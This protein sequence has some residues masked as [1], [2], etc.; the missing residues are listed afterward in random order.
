[1]PPP[2][3]LSKDALFQRLNANHH[4]SALRQNP[5]RGSNKKTIRMHLPAQDA[6]NPTTLKSY[7]PTSSCSPCEQMDHTPPNNITQP[8][9]HYLL[10]HRDAPFVIKY[11]TKG[12]AERNKKQSKTQTCCCSG[13]I[14]EQNSFFS[15]QESRRDTHRRADISP[16]SI[17]AHFILL[18]CGKKHPIR[19]SKT[20]SA[21]ALFRRWRKRR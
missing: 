9:T 3:S 15:R 19:R 5:P 12:V 20:H 2:P 16:A 10:N 21:S 8:S 17:V 11:S 18:R 1:M 7:Q 14:I 13:F 4:A 6:P